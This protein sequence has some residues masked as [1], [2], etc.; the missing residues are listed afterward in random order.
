MARPAAK[1]I[2]RP[3]SN[4]PGPAT[5][6]DDWRVV[7]ARSIRSEARC[8]GLLDDYD[9]EADDADI[10]AALVEA[11]QRWR[12]ESASESECAKPPLT[13]SKPVTSVRA[14]LTARMKCPAC[15]T[16]GRF[17]LSLP[18]GHVVALNGDLTYDCA[19]EEEALE[20]PVFC[21]DCMHTAPARDFRGGDV[22]L[23]AWHA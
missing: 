12:N 16:S 22:G 23:A 10:A 6:H 18:S 15:G 21:C 13:V 9:V 1:T 5:Q 3:V 8:R 14:T 7:A 2:V 17:I 4:R 11:L 19:S 20:M